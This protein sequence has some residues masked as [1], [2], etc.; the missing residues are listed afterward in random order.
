MPTVVRLRSAVC[1]LGRFP[2]LAGVDLDVA[3]GEIVLL[4]GANGA[5]K[6]TLL[7]LLAGLVPLYSGEASCS[8]RSRRDRRERPP[9]PRARRP[10]DLLLRRPH[11]AREPPLRG[12]RR[13]ARRRDGRRRARAGRARPRTPTSR[14]A[15]S[16]P[17]SAAGSRSR[18]RWSRDPKLLLLDEPHA[19]LDAEGRAVLDEIVTRGAERGP[20]ACCIASHE[21]D[22]AR[23]LAHREVVLTA[24]Q[25]ALASTR[26]ASDEQRSVLAASESRG[27]GIPGRSERASR[28]VNLWREVRLVAGKDLRIEARSRVTIQQI[29]PF[30]LIVLLLFA[31]AL[32]PDRGVLKRVAPGLFWVTVL[33]AVAARGVAC[34]RDRGRQRRAR[35]SAPLGP[36]RPGALPRQGR[37]HRGAAA[38]AR[39]GARGLRGACSTASS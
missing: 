9:R 7:R 36:R 30:G 15:S 14:T 22:R 2:A 5:G 33:L 4:S 16:R 20:H 27:R 10:R 21:L 35:R 3:A 31:F 8:A 11:R 18:S 1:L 34:V 24:G 28:E 12:A 13:R 19:G 25:A 23:A 37:G 17:G 6:T 26:R 39:G 32:D 38:R 29:L